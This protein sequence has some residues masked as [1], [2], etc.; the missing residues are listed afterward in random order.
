MPFLNALFE[1]N[2]D[3]YQ[4][5]RYVTQKFW[6]NVSSWEDDVLI[7]RHHFQRFPNDLYQRLRRRLGQHISLYYIPKHTQD[8]LLLQFPNTENTQLIE[9]TDALEYYELTQ[10]AQHVDETTQ[11]G[12]AE[13]SFICTRLTT[14]VMNMKIAYQQYVT[15]S[16]NPTV[17]PI[18]LATLHE[19]GI[20]YPYI[21]NM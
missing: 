20:R 13:I 10:I 2:I 4:P 1:C 14:A 6:G 18:Q 7:F 17:T 5:S 21:N 15:D 12:I 16:N 3:E 8:V 11:N 9:S 19:D